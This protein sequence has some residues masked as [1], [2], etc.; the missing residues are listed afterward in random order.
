M[1]LIAEYMKAKEHIEELDRKRERAKGALD[2]LMRRLEKEHDVKSVKEAK[3]LIDQLVEDEKQHT[4]EIEEGMKD[5]VRLYGE[6][7]SGL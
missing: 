2:E 3:R 4:E 7:L 6:R 5:I 1:T